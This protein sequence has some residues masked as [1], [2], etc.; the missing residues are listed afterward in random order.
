MLDFETLAADVDSITDMEVLRAQVKRLQIQLAIRRE[1]QLASGEVELHN[2]SEELK[3]GQDLKNFN[4][5]QDH[6]PQLEAGQNQ[7]LG[8]QEVNVFFSSMLLSLL[9][10]SLT[11]LIAVGL[12]LNYYFGLLVRGD[13]VKET[14]ELIFED[15]CSRVEPLVPDLLDFMHKEAVQLQPGK[16]LNTSK[17][18]KLVRASLPSS[19]DGLREA[20]DSVDFGE[21]C[22]RALK[23]PSLLRAP[24]ALER[25]TWFLRLYEDEDDFLHWHCDNNFTS[26]SRYTLVVNLLCNEDN[27]SHLLTE[28]PRGG[29][30]VLACKTGNAWLMNGA[31]TRHAVSRQQ[32]GG[33]RLS[34]VVPLYERFQYAP[35]GRLRQRLR[36]LW[37]RAFHL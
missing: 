8:E 2:C 36:G 10:S 4:V 32:F 34:L 1:V 23:K 13:D 37:Y 21:T 35:L 7:S 29:I 25:Y 19:L 24:E 15:L 6:L 11:I 12:A 17:G 31:Q 3:R 22:G 27:A 20:I 28:G 26:S 9:L 14:R 5:A 33:C 16:N 30:R 18:R